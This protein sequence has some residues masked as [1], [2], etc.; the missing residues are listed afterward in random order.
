MSSQSPS[1]S[2]PSQQSPSPDHSLTKL[3]HP[4][5]PIFW[6]GADTMGHYLLFIHNPAIKSLSFVTQGLTLSTASL[7]NLLFLECSKEKNLIITMITYRNFLLFQRFEYIFRIFQ[8]DINIEVQFI[9]YS[10]SC[11]RKP[12]LSER[13]R[14]CRADDLHGSEDSVLHLQSVSVTSLIFP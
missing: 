9:I 3:E 13:A 2:L 5:N 14:D 4:H 6:T 7:V 1:P 8:N 10:E 12:V 11:N